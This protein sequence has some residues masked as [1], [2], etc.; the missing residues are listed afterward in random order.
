ME[1]RHEYSVT[2][3]GQS[4]GPPS[5][6]ETGRRRSHCHGIFD[7]GTRGDVEAY[8]AFTGEIVGRPQPGPSSIPVVLR[9][10]FQT[11]D[12]MAEARGIQRGN[13]VTKI[14]TGL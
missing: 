6:R 11:R 10:Q 12:A 13:E 3:Q 7:C 1:L 5:P 2:L 9:Y 8:V 4:H 14:S